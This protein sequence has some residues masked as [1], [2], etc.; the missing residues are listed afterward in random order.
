MTWLGAS[1]TKQNFP[2]DSVLRSEYDSSVLRL[3]A[4][5][6]QRGMSLR[7]LSRISG[8]GLATLVRLEAGTFDPRLSTLRKLTKALKVT[9]AELIGD[10]KPGKGVKK[11]GC[12]S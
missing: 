9:V 7:G 4:F 5:R 11:R 3:R 2:L 8:V 1:G 10:S 12:Q 6:E